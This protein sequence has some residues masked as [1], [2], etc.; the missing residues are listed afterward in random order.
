[1]NRGVPGECAVS[2]FGRGK[3]H[4]SVPG[5]CEMSPLHLRCVF[6]E[7]D[8]SKFIKRLEKRVLVVNS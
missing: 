1:M 7:C 4:N 6:S 5:K 2:A 3:K 8:V